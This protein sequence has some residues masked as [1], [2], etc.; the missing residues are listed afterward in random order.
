MTRK[1]Y[2][3]IAAAVGRGS[4]L[5]GTTRAYLVAELSQVFAA[6]NPR[7]DRGKFAEAVETHAAGF[8]EC[9]GVTL[10]PLAE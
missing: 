1:D 2:R 8:C 7:Y 3:A 6:D 9:E 4:A 10:S 5:D